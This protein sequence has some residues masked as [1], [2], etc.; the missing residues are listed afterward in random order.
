MCA[1][2]CDGVHGCVMC[3]HAYVCANSVHKFTTLSLPSSQ[4]TIHLR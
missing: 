4:D 1:G 2:V 3:V